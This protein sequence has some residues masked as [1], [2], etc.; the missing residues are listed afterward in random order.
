MS[1][2]DLMHLDNP[3][4]RFSLQ[5]CKGEN[6]NFKNCSVYIAGVKRAV[7]SAR[8]RTERYTVDSFKHTVD[9]KEGENQ[10]IAK[11][12]LGFLL[13]SHAFISLC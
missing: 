6:L 8:D 12:A 5:V 9:S 7:A 2:T 1:T 3:A 4:C 13:L 11:L 10:H